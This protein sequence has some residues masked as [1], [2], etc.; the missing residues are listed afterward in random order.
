MNKLKKE[1]VLF[2]GFCAVTGA[3]GGIFT[4]LFTAESVSGE[5]IQ[6]AI[7]QLGSQEAF[8]AVAA[9]Q[10]LLYGAIC[11]LFGKIL[12]EK[13]GLWQ[14]LRIRKQPLNVALFTAVIS[15]IYLIVPDVFIFGK[16]IPAVAESYQ[17][18][19]SAVYCLSGI[20]YGGIVEEIMMRLFLMSLIAFLIWKIFLRKKQKELLPVWLFVSANIIT[21]LLFAAGH[22]PATA[23]TLGITPMILVRCFLLNGGL[24]LIFGRLYRKHGIQYAWIAHMGCHVVSKLIWL[25]FI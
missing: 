10:G 3:L 25:V 2:I 15:G 9:I 8:I 16:Y 24:G 17:A 21:A 12:S 18:K 20:I 4:A 14:E 6:E 23:I 19:P 1:F 13:V 7:R 22:L 11:G 5:Q